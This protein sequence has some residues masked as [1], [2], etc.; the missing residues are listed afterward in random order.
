MFN[1][2]FVVLCLT[3]LETIL[4]YIT[5]KSF[6]TKRNIENKIKSA[7]KKIRTGETPTEDE[8]STCSFFPEI[9]LHFKATQDEINIIKEYRRVQR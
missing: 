3:A 5:G 4:L 8:I 9:L 2:I 1:Y 7:L 6:M